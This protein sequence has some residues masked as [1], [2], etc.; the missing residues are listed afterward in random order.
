MYVQE[1]GFLFL[2]VVVPVKLFF[3]SETVNPEIIC[4]VTGMWEGT[5]GIVRYL[6]AMGEIEKPIIAKHQI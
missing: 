3:L 2:V 4:L 6:L 5:T 1:Y